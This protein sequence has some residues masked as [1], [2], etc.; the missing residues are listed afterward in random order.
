M[1]LLGTI[2]TIIILV[3]IVSIATYYLTKGSLNLVVK[4]DPY[5]EKAESYLITASTIGW[6]S[7]AFIIIG[8]IG[9]AWTGG[10][11]VKGVEMLTGKK[12]TTSIITYGFLTLI[13]L[14]FIIN[15]ILAVA[16]AVNIK[17]GVDFEKNKNIYNDC[18]IIGG[19]FIGITGLIIIYT[20][21]QWFKGNQKE[22]AIPPPPPPPKPVKPPKPTTTVEKTVVPTSTVLIK[23]LIEAG[24][25]PDQIK[26]ILGY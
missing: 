16:A 6:I 7:I 18:A 23:N 5:Q 8:G 3:I 9:L 1:S 19:L 2:F 20:I 12:T 22:A 13:I 17:K 15:G 11:K 25:T 21:Y 4:D 26:I 14:V 10:V 24:L